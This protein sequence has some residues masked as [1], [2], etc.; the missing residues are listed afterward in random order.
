MEIDTFTSYDD[1]LAFAHSFR[2]LMKKHM[3]SRMTMDYKDFSLIIPAMVNGAFACELLDELLSKLEKEDK[4]TYDLIVLRC[5]LALK[6]SSNNN[7]YDDVA[8]I[9]DLNTISNL[10][11]EIRYFYEPS[12]HAKAYNLA[13]IGVFIGVLEIICESKFGSRPKKT[14]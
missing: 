7:T 10:F 4:K 6:A 3:Q 12:L 8:F 9:N 5:I 13:F 1:G 2:V 11:V 14:D